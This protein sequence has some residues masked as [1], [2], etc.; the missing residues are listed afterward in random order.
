MIVHVR[1]FAQSRDLAGAERVTLELSDSATVA[2]LKSE[3]AARIPSLHGLLA[4][5]SFA[6]DCELLGNSTTIPAEAEIACLPPFSG[7]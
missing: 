6:M 2:E 3:L 5:C 1:L 7:G 4:S